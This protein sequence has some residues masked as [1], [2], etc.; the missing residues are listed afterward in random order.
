[1]PDIHQH[2]T[3]EAKVVLDAGM[4]LARPQSQSGYVPYALVPNGATLAPLT[5]EEPAPLHFIQQRP[6]FRDIPSFIAYVLRFKD[7]RTQLW[8]NEQKGTI[9]AVL[10]Y[11]RAASGPANAPDVGS[12][13]PERC[14]HIATFTA[15]APPEWQEWVAKDGE[16]QNQEAFATFIEDQA[17]FIVDPDAARMLEIALSLQVSS[18]HTFSRAMRLDNGQ[19]QLNYVENLDGRA[20]SKGDVVIP[21]VI[22]VSLAPFIGC[23][24][25]KVEARFRWRLEG[26]RMS[27]WF[28]LF[29]IQDIQRE[30]F[31]GLTD[32]VRDETGIAPYLGAH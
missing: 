29:R 6:T 24:R 26:G 14:A 18:Q 28:D 21:K 20:G 12:L 5:R 9:I 30:A 19:V 10:D 4:A 15:E 23:E 31:K 13:Q 8:A 27:L 25:R 11:H 2:S 17:P 16:A 7:E 22:S 1:V 32:R 3:P